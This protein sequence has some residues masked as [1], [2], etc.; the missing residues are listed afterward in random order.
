MD[1]I[2]IAEGVVY[3]LCRYILPKS[4]VQALL[5]LLRMPG[6]TG[7]VIKHSFFSRP[8]AVHSLVHMVI[9]SLPCPD[10]AP[11]EAAMQLPPQLQAYA[12]QLESQVRYEI[13]IRLLSAL[14][15]RGRQLGYHCGQPRLLKGT[16]WASVAGVDHIICQISFSIQ[17]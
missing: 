4:C 7:D 14:V 8:S 2:V 12:D 16:P 5:G 10:G 15:Q 11:A 3:H 13:Q 17:S 9:A 6:A 1:L